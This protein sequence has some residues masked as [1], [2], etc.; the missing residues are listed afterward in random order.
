MLDDGPDPPAGR[1]TFKRGHLP[2][3]FN[4]PIHEC[5]VP[6]LPASIRGR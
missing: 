5:V 4:I 3:H 6:C 1:G 2:A